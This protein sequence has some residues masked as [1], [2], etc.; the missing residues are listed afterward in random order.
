MMPVDHPSIPVNKPRDSLSRQLVT[1]FLLLSLI[2]LC[3]SSWIS[4]QQA[5][6]ALTKEA[7]SQL[8]QT[9]SLKVEF[10]KNWFDF[11]VMDIGSQAELTGNSSLLSSLIEGLAAS[12]QPA[13]EYVKSYDW[14]RRV[15][16]VQ[17]GLVTLSR[18]YDY[19]Y[20]MF[21]I[22]KQG[23]ILYSLA[24]GPD[25]GS[26]LLQGEYSA[27][28]FSQA[29]KNTLK[30]GAIYFSGIER[31]IP[32][33]N[34]ISGFISAPLLD[35]EGEKLG[36]IA[37]QLRLDRI[38]KIL[39]THRS[40]DTTMRHYL[41]NEQ[42]ILLSPLGAKW[43]E[44]L[45]RVI[46]S[47]YIKSNQ[48]TDKRALQPHE[49]I[50]PNNI[51]VIGTQN[52][53]TVLNHHWVL[54]SEIE[55]RE[56]QAAAN[57]LAKVTATL[58]LLTV[59]IVI[60][61][62]VLLTRRITRPIIAL[63]DIAK[64]VA[65]GEMNE[66]VEITSQNEIGML[67]QAFNHMLS[68]RQKHDRAL[69]KAKE[70]AEVAD[71]AKSEFLASMSHEIRTPMNG[72]LGMLR[73]LLDTNLDTD[74]HHHARIAQS[75]AQS[76]LTLINDIL[77]FSKIEAGKLEL[78]SL[79]F[80][81]RSMLG[82]FAESIALQAQDKGLELI[83]DI[84]GIE[85]SMVRGDP[86]RLRQILTNLVGNAIKFTQ[87]G[88][89][90]IRLKLK[91]VDDNI[92]RLEGNIIDTGMGIAKDKIP[93]LF[94]TF[95]QV[96]SSTTRKFGGTGLGLSIVRR[97]CEIMQG[98]ITA[99]SEPGKGSSF[100]F[101]VCLQKCDQSIAVIPQVDITALHLLIVDDNESNLQV[102]HNQLEHWG[103]S[104][105]KANSAEQAMALC[106]QR[107]S[108]NQIPFF[109]IA[110]I[111]MQMPNKDGA[112]LAEKLKADARFNSMK[113]VIMTLMGSRGDA[114]F[115]AELGFS[116]Y[117]TKP[118]T[119]SDLFEALAI[120]TD[121]GEALHQAQPLLTHHY[122]QALDRQQVKHSIKQKL[123]EFPDGARILLVDD[124]RVNQLVAKSML[125]KFNLTVDLADDG[126]DA[127]DRLRQAI[128]DREISLVLM[129]CL[130]PQMD[131]FEASKA[132]RSG[133]AGQAY[134]DI[135]IIAMTANAMQGY[136][137]KCIDAGMN[138]YIAKPVDPDL[139]KLKLCQWLL[140]PKQ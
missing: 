29:V 41:V 18:R 26:H 140:P 121:D 89:I 4:Y 99:S 123:N 102:L 50:G 20:D 112:D 114:K 103:A 36:A 124:N 55:T 136:R 118:A 104:V 115:F 113:L 59:G 56:A 28:Q 69:I 5:N 108:E 48:A 61:L 16:G 116:A 131:G 57:W 54:I 92:W 129:D 67:T 98:D 17:N 22:D 80:D 85:Q 1:W 12:Q 8:Q 130:M 93:Q 82:E 44:V 65:D 72:I 83:L 88:E 139:L 106:D 6:Q 34:K 77:D 51:N 125:K 64:K 127:L 68:N 32:S 117:F 13:S 46:D 40:T 110:F 58:V 107:V 100:N 81:L 47:A 135:P 73:L 11:R 2:P 9:A 94:D 91:S 119:T 101:K 52:D 24:R 21:L 111:D 7:I 62:A 15:D 86:G 19:I 42:G 35:E 39:Q 31:Y 74:Q 126:L 133:A 105:V 45:N 122:L 95:T 25:L 43:N 23:H 109:N 10:I 79:S 49:Y 134:K 97:L 14:A 27:T 132:I 30:T 138:D 60:F 96:D 71:H 84:T 63:S 120:I 37:F 90:I 78:E 66:R 33:N 137:Q 3:L 87:Q 128:G 75:S 70:S 76:L 38:F 53:V